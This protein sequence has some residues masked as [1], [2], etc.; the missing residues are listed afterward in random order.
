MML[1]LPV[2]LTATRH[3]PPAS[4]AKVGQEIVMFAG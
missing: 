4:R 2:E 1:A 3:P